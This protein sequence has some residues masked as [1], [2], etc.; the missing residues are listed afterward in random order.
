LQS[1]FSEPV[2]REHQK[3]HGQG[4]QD[5]SQAHHSPPSI[6]FVLQFA[7]KLGAKLQDERAN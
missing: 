3:H 7:R 2:D 6:L 1:H 5:L 4:D